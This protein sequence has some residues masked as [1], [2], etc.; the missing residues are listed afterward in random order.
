MMLSAARALILAVELGHGIR[1]AIERKRFARLRRTDQLVGLLIEL[2]HGI[3]LGGVGFDL[4]EMIFQRFPRRAAA[5]EAFFGDA[6]GQRDVAHL[7]ILLSG[8]GAQFKGAEFRAEIAGSALQRHVGH[9]HISRQILARSELFRH[10]R[11]DAGMLNG[12]RGQIAGEHLIGGLRVIG[13]VAGDGADDG[14]FVRDLRRMREI[15]AEDDAGDFGFDHAERPAILDGSFRF[16]VPRFL[17]G[18]AAGQN[19]LNDTFRFAFGTGHAA[20]RRGA[21]RRR[22]LR[23]R[24]SN[25]AESG[26][27]RPER[28]A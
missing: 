5:V 18:Q 4:P 13:N 22:R 17:S 27:Y 23:Q 25:R 1:F 11:A 20:V 26:P 24:N 9:G 12:R 19:D 14:D 3:E 6:F 16:R 21:R 15:L 7:E 28:P 8:I 2:A 10:H